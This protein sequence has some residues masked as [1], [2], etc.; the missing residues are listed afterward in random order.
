MVQSKF[1][2]KFTKN[3]KIPNIRI[4]ELLDSHP[5]YVKPPHT[6]QG[7]NYD[8]IIPT[9]G[10]K[11]TQGGKHKESYEKIEEIKKKHSKQTYLQQ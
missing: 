10:A 7:S 4:Q 1:G 9:V 3:L 5:L 8:I 2:D 6:T 11:I